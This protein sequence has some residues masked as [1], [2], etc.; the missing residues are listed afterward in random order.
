MFA[1]VA[2]HEIG[3]GL[4]LGHSSGAVRYIMD[5]A[6]LINDPATDFSPADK[7]HLL[8]DCLPGKNR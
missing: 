2:A 4:G 8:T 7:T 1:S 3:H 5:P 6:T